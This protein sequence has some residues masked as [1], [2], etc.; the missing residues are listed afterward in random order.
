MKTTFFEEWSWFKFINLR[1]TLRTKLKFYTSVA[2]GLKVKVRQFLRLI[3]TFAEVAGEKL[4]RR[5]LFPL[6]DRFEIEKIALIHI[7][8]TWFLSSSLRSTYCV[9]FFFNVHA[10]IK[11]LAYFN[12]ALIHTV[13]NEQ[14]NSSM[15]PRSYDSLTS[16]C[17]RGWDD[18][19]IYPLFK[20]GKKHTIS[21]LLKIVAVINMLINVNFQI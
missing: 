18:L 1:L 14:A 6:F 21:Y 12:P 5:P 7:Y 15:E 8:L 19:F 11:S 9:Y 4:E 2:K 16:V 3:P 13:S 20:V 10:T 17:P